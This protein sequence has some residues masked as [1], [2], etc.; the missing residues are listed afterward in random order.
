[1][2]VRPREEIVDL[3]EHTNVKYFD[4]SNNQQR[5]DL[6]YNRTHNPDKMFTHCY[7]ANWPQAHLLSAVKYS[8]L[9]A[10]GD[11]VITKPLDLNIPMVEEIAT[12]VFPDIQA[13]IRM[14]DHYRNKG[15]V[16]E[17]HRIMPDLQL[18][19]KL[20][21]LR[22][23]RMWLVEESTIEE[24]DRRRALECGVIWDLVTHIVSLI[25]LYFIDP[26]HVGLAGYSKGD[27]GRLR[28]V[29]LTIEKVL[30]MRYV[31]CELENPNIET[32]SV[33]EVAIH[34]E[35]R[36]YGGWVPIQ[37]KGL[38]VAGKGAKRGISTRGSVKQLDFNFER[39]NVSLNLQTGHISPPF[40]DFNPS[41]ETGF[42]RP[43]VE[44]LTHSY[45]LDKGKS[46]INTPLPGSYHGGVPFTQSL[47]NVKI[48]EEIRSHPFG[49]ELYGAINKGTQ[50]SLFLI[51]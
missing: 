11:I 22:D 30:R 51:G 10:G 13:K 19:E 25:Q 32:L 46:K 5:M 45:R 15:S 18:K 36:T 47:Y 38:L 16:R 28:N 40:N 21:K 6:L 34:F 33:I 3:P 49:Y 23:F 26:P 29:K 37:I 4:V 2:D 24:E 39:S 9:C 41:S 17:L 48:I 31:E 27:S 43:I 12:G 7:I 42:H 50:Y 14:D 1:M 44:L 35:H 20:G 8:T